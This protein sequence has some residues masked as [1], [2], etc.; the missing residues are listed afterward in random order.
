M[1][2]ST[3]FFPPSDALGLTG[4]NVDVYITGRQFGQIGIGD[5]IKNSGGLLLTEA[6]PGGDIRE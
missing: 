5:V 2:N 4:C 6:L 3:S 1:K